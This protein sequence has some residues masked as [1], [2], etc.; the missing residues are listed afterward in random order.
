[1]AGAMKRGAL[2]PESA[3]LVKQLTMGNREVL[4]HGDLAALRAKMGD[5]M[6]A[7]GPVLLPIDRSEKRHASTEGRGVAAI[8]YWPPDAVRETAAGNGRPILVYFHGGAFTHF[9][10]DTH[11]AVARYLCNRASCIV[12]NVDY[13]LAPEHKF[14]AALDDAYAALCWAASHAEELGG[15]P[16]KIAVAGESAGGTLSV[17]LSLLAKQKGEPKI[18]LQIPMCASLTLDGL[19]QYESWQTLGSGEFLLSKGSIADIR[20][21]YLTRP[22]EALNPLVSPILAP[23]LAG[24]PPALVMTAEFDPLVDEAAH[25]A[26]RLSDAGVPVTYRCFEG[27]IHSFMIM[28]GKISLGYSALDLAAAQIRAL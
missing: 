11:D 1:M 22:E 10:A 6:K 28:A 13:R 14:P 4:D 3:A 15:N 21:L 25:Y 26:R 27:T 17:A 19:E 18:A 2:E 5:F 12:V 23:D 24:L 7:C 8:V 16:Q 20:S 9:S